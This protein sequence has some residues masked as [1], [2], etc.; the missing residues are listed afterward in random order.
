[1]SEDIAEYVQAIKDWQEKY[2]IKKEDYI[3][4]DLTLEQ[5]DELKKLDEQGL[6]WTQHGTCE[7]EMVSFGMTIF[8]DHA[9]T[10]QVASGCGCYQTY[11]FYVGEEKGYDE[12]IAMGAYEPCPVCNEDG[13][14]DGKEN[15]PGPDPVEGAEFF[16]CQD[17]WIQWHFD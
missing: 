9:L 5:L 12:Y 10:G 8:G 16:E 2:K 6:V 15:C 1:M 11:C 14:G 13:E 3:L 4:E 7:N 17:G